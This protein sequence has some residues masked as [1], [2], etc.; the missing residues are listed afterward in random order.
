VGILIA[1]WRFDRAKPPE[2]GLFY[3]QGLLYCVSRFGIEFLRDTPA[4]LA[5]LTSA[6][7]ACVAGILFFGFRLYSQIRPLKQKEASFAMS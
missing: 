5:G 3:L 1:L 6:Q 7:W 4:P 2:N